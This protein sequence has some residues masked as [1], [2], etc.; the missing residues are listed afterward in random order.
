MIQVLWEFVVKEDA[1][2]RFELAYG[3]GGEWSKLFARSVGY[4]GTT[5]LQ[6]LA[7]PGRYLTIDLWD[8]EAQR[9]QFLAERRTQV[10]TLD[11]VFA[12]WTESEFE[13][14]TFRM[15][16]QATVRPVPGRSRAR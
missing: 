5:L 11:G 4:R 12:Q 9:T 1:R 13:L 2:R 6:D 10:E 14:G 7:H 15:L 8:S 16:A 3:P